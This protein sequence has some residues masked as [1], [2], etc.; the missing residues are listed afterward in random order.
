MKIFWEIFVLLAISF[1]LAIFV[2]AEEEKKEEETEITP[3]AE[4]VIGECVEMV[5]YLDHKMRRI[6]GHQQVEL[7]MF[8][9]GCFFRPLKTGE[10]TQEDIR[11]FRENK[12]KEK[13]AYPI[14]AAYMGGKSTALHLIFKDR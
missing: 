5:E 13:K 6:G 11:V 12:W 3:A 4:K 2:Y 10:I 14:E 8:F 1:S 9:A 7:T